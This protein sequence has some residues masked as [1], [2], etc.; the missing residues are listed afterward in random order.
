MPPEPESK[1]PDSKQDSERKAGEELISEYKEKG[2][3]AMRAGD[4]DKTYE[5]QQA[6]RGLRDEVAKIS[7]DDKSSSVYRIL[8]AART[9]EQQHA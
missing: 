2:R 9:A 5:S 1:E 4:W 8:A 3:E 6:V 7:S